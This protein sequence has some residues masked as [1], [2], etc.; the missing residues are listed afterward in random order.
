MKTKLIPTRIVGDPSPN[1]LIRAPQQRRRD[2]P[3]ERLGGLEVN[4]QLRIRP[5]LNRRIAGLRALQIL[6]N[7][8][9]P[10]RARRTGKARLP[11]VTIGDLLEV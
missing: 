9:R 2:R 3:P 11:T 1:D 4:H 6:V 8:F 5:L 7:G 10:C